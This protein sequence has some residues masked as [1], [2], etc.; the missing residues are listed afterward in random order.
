MD[1]YAEFG[2]TS[3]VDG[4]YITELK[5]A[6]KDTEDIKKEQTSEILVIPNADDKQVYS[7]L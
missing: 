3:F 5:V 1:L 6:K 7:I 2:G 4:E